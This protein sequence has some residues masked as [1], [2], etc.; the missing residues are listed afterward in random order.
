MSITIADFPA[1]RIYKAYDGRKFSHGETIAIPF[2]TRSHGVLYRFFTLGS[3]EGYA[4][5]NG[6]CPHAALAR[7]LANAE[8]FGDGRERYWAGANAVCISNMKEAKREVPGFEF[9]D[10][11]IFQGHRFTLEKAPNDNCKLRLIGEA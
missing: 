11:I 7:H 10:E 3:V 4:I 9:G 5:K 1:Y 6:E 8:K 2:N